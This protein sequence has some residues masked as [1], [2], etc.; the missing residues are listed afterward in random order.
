METGSE[1]LLLN[2]EPTACRVLQV[3][4]KAPTD[5]PSRSRACSDATCESLM[6]S[7]QGHLPD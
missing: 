2:G 4:Y 7:G 5:I 6:V 1:T 3:E